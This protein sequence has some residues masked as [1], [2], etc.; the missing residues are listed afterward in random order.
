MFRHACF[1]VL[2]SLSAYSSDPQDYSV[3]GDCCVRAESLSK[4][5]EAA[6]DTIADL[7]EQVAALTAQVDYCCGSRILCP[8]G[9]F[10]VKAFN[11]MEFE[12]SCEECAPG[13]FADNIGSI[14][15]APCSPGSIAP[16]TG[17][18]TCQ[19]CSTGTFAAHAFN[20]ASM[21]WEAS[22][23]ECASGHFADN[24]G[25][26]ACAPCSPGSIAPAHRQLR[27]SGMLH[28]DVRW[29]CLQQRVDGMGIHRFMRGLRCWVACGEKGPDM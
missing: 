27:M 21:E 15:C 26:T 25:S 19:E 2:L 18:S 23:E 4:E 14:A 8:T 20:N 24:K 10:V 28:R 1:V 16:A 11:R 5:L 17:S 9:T 6:E 3:D 22:C 7:M 13:H 12:A 29:T